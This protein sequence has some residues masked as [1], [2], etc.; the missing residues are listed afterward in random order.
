MFCAEFTSRTALPLSS[1][2]A[3]TCKA[4]ATHDQ[5]TDS[6]TSYHRLSD[7]DSA[8]NGMASVAWLV[9]VAAV[10]AVVC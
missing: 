2:L 1:A 7:G 8:S 5:V 4:R 10:V 3:T 9:A 6:M